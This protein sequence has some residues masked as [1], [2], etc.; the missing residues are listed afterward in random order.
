MP[1]KTDSCEV[2][3]LNYLFLN[4]APA[5]IGNSNLFISLHTSDPGDGGNQSTNEVGYTGYARV[6]VARSGT[7][8]T[9]VSGSM[10]NTSP[11]AFPAC[12][13]G[14][15]TATHFGIG[16]SSSGAG[17]LLYVGSLTSSL[18]ISSGITPQF[19]ANGLTISED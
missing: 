17:T 1:G 14:S 2:D 19:A 9:L 7:G 16:T 12:T 18:A 6:A 10:K 11:I 5:W 4:T 15:A 3:V 8:F 13:G